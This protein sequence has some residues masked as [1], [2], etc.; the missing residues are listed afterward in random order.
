MPTERRR[1]ISLGGRN[2]DSIVSA[3]PVVEGLG[4]SF[5]V[6]SEPKAI[7]SGTHIR[8]HHRREPRQ[9]SLKK[10]SPHS[11]RQIQEV[12]SKEDPPLS[13]KSSLPKRQSSRKSRKHSS[14]KCEK[15]VSTCPITVVSG[16]TS[17]I[18]LNSQQLL[19]RRKADSIKSSVKI[20]RNNITIVITDIQG[21]TH[22][23]EEDASAMKEALILHDSI[24]RK[25]YA[26]HSGYEITTEGD[27]FQLAFQHPIDA[28]SFCLQ[29]QI[30]L[31]NANWSDTILRLE[32][33][34]LDKRNFLNGL[35]VRM[36]LHHGAT[37]S[38]I[39]PET[40]RI[41]Y[42]GET[43]VIAKCLVDICHGG[44]ILTT[45]ETFRQVSGMAE[46][47]LGS[48]QVLDCGAHIVGQE[49]CKSLLQLVPKRLAFQ[50]FNHR[51]IQKKEF[52]QKEEGRRFPPLKSKRKM[53]IDFLH[54]PYVNDFVTLLF[55]NT[56]VVRENLANSAKEKNS[57]LL[58]MKVRSLL[59][60]FNSPG[61]ECQEENGC[62]MIAFHSM[63]FAVSF[64]LK[65]VQ[66]LD[67]GS[68][69]PFKVKV[70]IHAGYF[71]SMG[72]HA[73]TGRADYFGPIVNRAA[74]LATAAE[75]SQVLVGVAIENNEKGENGV[76]DLRDVEVRFLRKEKFKGV[77]KE[78]AVYS[79]HK[80]ND[81]LSRSR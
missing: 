9:N 14:R 31:Y 54:A 44:Q 21:S 49:L 74:R 19:R 34:K 11:S 47:Y 43:V 13:R 81:V 59:R 16:E 56:T 63:P 2:A 36:S 37:M 62:W 77:S 28:F 57:A 46:R 53:G 67:R 39:H 26:T 41:F 51:G 55:M 22:L 66:W 24:I 75:L 38:S 8:L 48:P 61:Y 15:L 68:G 7:H 17:K 70:G 3:P 69:A 30:D 80:R 64:G 33:A 20:P 45:S 29:T 65:V 40:K 27:S 52:A 32:N 1:R 35:R 50:Y 73:I 71:T 12:K 18:S 6:Q 76:P 42:S 79:C 58:A 5:S 78:I 23:W 72:P 60:D 10:S 25:C 4:S